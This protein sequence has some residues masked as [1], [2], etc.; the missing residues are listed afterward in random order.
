MHVCTT[1]ESVPKEIINN[2]GDVTLAVDIMTI[3]K[4]PFM[5]TTSRNVQFGTAQ[6][7]LNKTNNTIMMSTQVSRMYHERGL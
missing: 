5:V 3:N 1:W 6:S 2:H 7:I 4:I